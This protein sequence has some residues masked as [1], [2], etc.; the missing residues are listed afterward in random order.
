MLNR[1]HIVITIFFILLLFPLVNSKTAFVLI[2]LFASLIPDVD[3]KTSFIGNYKIFRPLQF[4]V[5]HRG[6]F[7]CFIFMLFGILFFLCFYPIGAFAFFIG[8]GSHLFVDALTIEGVR[9]FYPLEKKVSGPIKTGGILETGIL[10]TF[11]V[12]DLILLILTLSKEFF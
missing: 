7:H 6:F 2:A 4:F 3:I 11:S 10:I 9:F 8:Y 5:E 12:L 1:T